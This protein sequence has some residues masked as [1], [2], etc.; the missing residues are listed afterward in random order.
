MFTTSGF[1]LIHH[2]AQHSVTGSCHELRISE[3]CGL[4]IDCG[5]FQGQEADQELEITFAV[6]HLRGLV[7]THVHI[8]HVGR[9]PYLIAA[10][11]KGPIFCSLASAHLL[12]TVLEDALKISFTR[13][14]RQIEYFFANHQEATA[15][16]RVQQLAAG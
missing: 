11:F 14:K 10:G 16:H 9:L 7:L 4:L 6:K 8:D 3:E 15:S 13:D 2:G 1:Q 12:P 5:I